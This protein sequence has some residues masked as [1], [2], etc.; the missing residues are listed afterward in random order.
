MHHSTSH[1]SEVSLSKGRFR[2][3]YNGIEISLNPSLQRGKPG[4]C[5]EVSLSKREV[6]RVL[7]HRNASHCSEVSLRK[8]EI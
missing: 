8:R 1:C 7:M 6:Q 4:F 5:S 2:G 3:I